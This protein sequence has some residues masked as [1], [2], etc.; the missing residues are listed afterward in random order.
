MLR[1]IKLN[2]GD[3]KGLNDTLMYHPDLINK[4]YLDNNG[5]DGNQL[6]LICEGIN[7]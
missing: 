5:L 3:A 7:Y 4:L 1:D 2:S 6:A